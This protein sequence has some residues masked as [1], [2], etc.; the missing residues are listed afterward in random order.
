MSDKLKAATI[1]AM[2]D[3]LQKGAT[4][5][6]FVNVDGKRR[7]G[8]VVKVNWYTTWV[9]VMKGAKTSY[10]IKRHN[11]KGNV[12]LCSFLSLLCPRS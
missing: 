10:T 8:R 1:E 4:I 2:N 12:K 7:L 5:M 3:Q 11:Q 6:L 9:K